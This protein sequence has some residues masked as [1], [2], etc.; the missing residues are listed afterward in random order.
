[1]KA[2]LSAALPLA[3]LAAILL[4]GRASRANESFSIVALPDTQNYV[5]N[6][7][8]AALFAQQTQWIADQVQTA[9]NPRNLQF[10]T[11]LGDV[12]SNGDEL[13]QMLR[14][15][16]AMDTLDG[17]IPY[18]VL[19]GNHDY[20]STG[21][22]T[23]GTDLYVEYFGP[24][25]FAD[26]SWYGGADPS[27]NNS[28]QRFSAGGYDFIHM[29]L[30]WQPTVNAPFREISPVDWAQSVLDANPDTPF[31]LSTHEHIDDSPAGRSGSGEAL[32]NELIRTNDQVFMVLNGHY[33]SVGG[34]N[35]GEYHQTSLNDADRPVFE[36]LQ[37]YQDYPNGGDGWLRLIEFDIPENK[38]RFETY[39]PVLD[40][41]QTETVQDVGAFAS[42]FDFDIDFAGRLAPIDIPDPPFDPGDQP[43]FV[44]QQG[45]DNYAGTLD[46]EL[47]SSGGDST[48][49]GAFEI[50]VDGDDGSP[51]QQPNQALIGFDDLVGVTVGEMPAGAQ[52]DKATIRLEVTNQGSGFT[53][54]EMLVGWDEGDTWQSFGA[55][56]QAND[57]EAKA[58]ATATV[59]ANNSSSNVPVGSLEIDVTTTIQAILDGELI[60][61]GW[62]LTPFPDGTNGLDFFTSEFEGVDLRPSL[63]VFTLPGDYNLDGIV[64]EVDYQV[65][66]SAYGTTGFSL[67]DGNRNGEVDAADYAIWRD[68]LESIATTGVP[69]CPACLSCLC[70]AVMMF[71]KRP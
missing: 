36:V 17:V 45:R 40:Q 49:G 25:R 61:N 28:Y 66:R 59:G 41:F 14:A 29:S 43:T 70:L 7:N 15:D 35:D 65:W 37:D 62:L 26:K 11:H 46:K 51:G 27:G 16:T 6:F 3:S 53:V 48:N 67:A 34:S 31:I 56:V 32:W 2:W 1:M 21:S 4:S 8:N 39:S 13:I 42:Q 24:D 30:E 50:S 47:R 52:I 58:D 54:H 5:N 20:A 33:H 60:N 57:V 68:G 23:T 63:E 19:P 55:G 69:E 64:D 22:K 71:T 44:F 38:I 9:G 10:V 12:V 18:G